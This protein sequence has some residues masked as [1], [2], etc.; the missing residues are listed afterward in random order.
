MFF[1]PVLLA[2][3]LVGLQPLG[4]EQPIKTIGIIS[5]VG[6]KLEISNIGLMVFANSHNTIDIH[7]WN[8]GREMTD[9]FKSAL[10]TRFDV[11][12]I[13]DDAPEFE[14][15]NGTSFDFAAAVRARLKPNDPVSYDAYLVIRSDTRQDIIGGTNQS[16]SGIGLYRHHGVDSEPYVFTACT[17]TLVDGHTF[18]ALADTWMALPREEGV[19]GFFSTL[20]RY[21]DYDFFAGVAEQAW[22]ASDTSFDPEQKMSLEASF[23]YLLDREVPFTVQRLG[24]AN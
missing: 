13:A 20:S 17:V 3:L 22:P 8:L 12:V 14:S 5:A 11:H 6:D 10:S 24:L 1:A 19:A 16:L 15:A 2:A 7:D 23:T 4:A 18:K 9:A 21:G